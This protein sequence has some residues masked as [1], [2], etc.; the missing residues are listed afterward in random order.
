MELSGSILK[1]FFY[2]LRKSILGKKLFKKT[3]Y[4]SGG[5]FPSLK[6]KKN[7]FEKL[8]YILIYGTY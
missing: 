7:H 1:A 2:F 5:N 3:S 4:I 6:I 8:S